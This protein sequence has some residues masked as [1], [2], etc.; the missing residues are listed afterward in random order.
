MIKTIIGVF[1]EIWNFLKIWLHFIVLDL[2]SI[3]GWGVLIVLGIYDSLKSFWEW[4]SG[5]I[6]QAQSSMAA[7]TSMQGEGASASGGWLN[8]MAG[9]V[10]LQTC[11]NVLSFFALLWA[12]VLIYRFVKSWIPAVS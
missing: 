4:V 2:W 9:F 10:P 11:V 8:V 6:T 5:L 7:V 3:L 1:V 12:A